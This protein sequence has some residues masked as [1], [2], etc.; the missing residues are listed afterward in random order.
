[1]TYCIYHIPGKKIGVSKD[2]KYRVEIQQG[3]KPGEYEIIEMS[4]DIDYISAREIELQKLYNY[5]VDITPYKNL[6]S[7]KMMMT[8][9][10]T[11]QTT[12]FPVPLNKLKGRLMD[13]IGMVIQTGFNRHELDT[14]LV[15]WI[16]RHAVTS[17]FN[18]D[19]CYVYNKA[20]SNFKNS[21]SFQD[22]L[23]SQSDMFT[24]IRRWADERGIYDKGDS[25]TQYVK[26]ME[27]AGELARALLKNDKPEVIDSIGDIVVVLTNLAKL[28]KL[29]IEDCIENAYETISNRTGK[30][31]NGTFVKNTL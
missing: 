31:M 19:R 26:L 30:M 15:D 21:F 9:N 28:E 20:M 1:M 27:E 22:K 18:E 10:V 14:D 29:D 25:K 24:K 16:M 12:T 8:I 4:D 17:Q 13:N 11:E 2:P 23:A 6:N 5:R 7:N 3:Y